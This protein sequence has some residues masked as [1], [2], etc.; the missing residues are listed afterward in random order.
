MMRF[1]LKNMVLLHLL[2]A[3]L[4][5]AWLLGWWQSTDEAVFW[6]FN[7]R[8]EYVP[9]ARVVALA[10]QRWVDGVTAVLMTSV[11]LH[12]IHQ[13]KGYARLRAICLVLIM[14]GCFSLQTGVGKALPI[15]RD[16][17]THAL[18]GVTLL[19]DIVPE[20]PAKHTSRN[21][22]PSDHGTGLCT[23][24]LFAV[25]RFPRRYLV[26]VLPIVMLFMMPRIMS[27]AHWLTDITSSSVPLAMITGAWLFHTPLSYVLVEM[28]SRPVEK[29][30]RQFL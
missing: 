26:A 9:F 6:F 17:P 13:C 14:A 28:L 23:F 10:N 22:Y 27:G 8:L 12:H 4:V 5:L 2:A 1:D 20:I 11:V 30:L 7:R 29:L 21:A 16:S 15:D 25:Y 18:E 3:G 19:V 24:L